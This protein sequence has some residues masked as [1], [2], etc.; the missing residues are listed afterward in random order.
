MGPCAGMQCSQECPEMLLIGWVERAFE[1]DGIV[2]SEQPG[3]GTF[4]KLFP[5]SARLT[6][7]RLNP[8]RSRRCR[9]FAVIRPS[10]RGRCVRGVRTGDPRKTD[11]AWENQIPP[12]SVARATR[13]IPSTQAAVR[14]GIFFSVA[15]VET[16]WKALV[17]L[18]S[19]SSRTRLKSQRKY[20]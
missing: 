3:T 1:G 4:R 2:I 11:A 8:V 9:V 17:R 18:R 12:N 14:S 10:Q 19:S 15:M 6:D 13:S 20:C 7:A 5:C 16:R